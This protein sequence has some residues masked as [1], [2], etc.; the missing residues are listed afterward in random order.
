MAETIAGLRRGILGLRGE[1]AGPCIRLG[2][3][4]P[5]HTEKV[6]PL[7]EPVKSSYSRRWLLM[8][9]LFGVALIAY[10]LRWTA[11][12][13]ATSR[14]A[15]PGV[16]SDIGVS[17]LLFSVLFWFE[18]RI[19]RRIIDSIRVLTG[20]DLAERLSSEADDPLMPGDFQHAY[21]PTETAISILERIQARD[22]DSVWV[23]TDPNLRLCRAQGW[24]FDNLGNLGLSSEY[25]TEW[26]NMADY[27]I[28][29]PHR[30]EQVW[31]SFAAT[32]IGQLTASFSAYAAGKAGWSQRRRVLGPR[33]EVVL[34]TPLPKN[35][36]HGY[37]ATGPTLLED[38]RDLLMVCVD[39]PSAPP[40]R[41]YLLAGVGR[42]APLPGWPP[43]WWVIDDPVA[44]EVH[45]GLVANG[46]GG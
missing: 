2:I 35:A 26:D 14:N 12:G 4:P 24:I 39:H 43:T 44:L 42:A 7:E 16:L 34:L 31:D 38:S 1:P 46:A 8:P 21:G 18:K 29:G 28:A 6:Q 40:G 30:G 19:E 27:L 23:M 32:E 20:W 41:I 5:V 15:V 33:H 37:I 36:P 3:T 25:S 11:T 10:N 45:P 22:Y 9:A 13:G 17:L